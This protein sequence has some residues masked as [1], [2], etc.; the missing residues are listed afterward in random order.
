LLTEEEIAIIPNEAS[1]NE[2]P[3]EVKSRLGVETE[4]DMEFLACLQR[5]HDGGTNPEIMQ[6]YLSA[7]AE[8]WDLDGSFYNLPYLEAT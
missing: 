8:G 5:A 7:V 2:L 3:Y 6:R 4:E 1:V